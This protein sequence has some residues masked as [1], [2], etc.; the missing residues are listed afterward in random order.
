MIGIRLNKIFKDDDLYYLDGSGDNRVGRI[1]YTRYFN[2]WSGN[3]NI[4]FVSVGQEQYP[5]TIIFLNT[6][7]TVI[8]NAS[9]YAVIGTIINIID[10]STNGAN[11]KFKVSIYDK[12]TIMSNFDFQITTTKI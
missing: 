5:T 1:V 12:C 2:T 8:N 6:A 4:Q 7:I 3:Y 10:K 9:V 11:F